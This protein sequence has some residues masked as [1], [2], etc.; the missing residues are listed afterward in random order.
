MRLSPLG[1]KAKFESL[2]SRMKC[3]PEH[4]NNELSSRPFSEL[5]RAS[6]A[7]RGW[8]SGPGADAAACLRKW[9]VVAL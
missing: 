2:K 1:G 9:R 3:G 5:S 4:R 6:Q 8:Q 7:A